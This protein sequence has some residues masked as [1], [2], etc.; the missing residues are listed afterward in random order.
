MKKIILLCVAFLSAIA[1]FAQQDSNR[2]FVFTD[3]D[4]NA[5]ENGATIERDKLEFDDF[6]EFK[7]IL[8]EVYVKQTATDKNYAVSMSVKINSID[9]GTLKVC[10]PMSCLQLVKPGT[11]DL[12]KSTL[13]E[14]ASYNKETGMANILTEWIP[15][16]EDAWGMCEAT[17]T[18]TTLIKKSFLDYT[19][20]G[21]SSEIT[22]RFINRDPAGSNV[23]G[24]PTKGSCFNGEVA[25]R[26]YGDVTGKG[27][28]LATVVI[29]NNED[30]T[31]NIAI[32]GMKLY[33]DL[34]TITFKNIPGKELRGITRFSSDMEF[35]EA[36]VVGSGFNRGETKMTV[37]G[38]FKKDKC[39]V[40]LA[41]KFQG[42]GDNPFQIWIGSPIE[43]D[44]FVYKV[45]AE[46]T[47]GD[48]TVTHEADE[49]RVIDYGDGTMKFVYPRFTIAESNILIGDY[50]VSNVS[51]S[52]PDENGYRNF[53]SN[54]AAKIANP[55]SFAAASG[56]G[57]EQDLPTI[58]S[59]RY[60][61]KSIEMK[62]EFMVSGS[63]TAPRARFVFDSTPKP[64]VY[65]G[66]ASSLYNGTS[67]DFGNVSVDV[68]G[69]DDTCIYEFVV[70][71]VA[72]SSMVIGNF[73]VT[74]VVGTKKSDGSIS[75]SFAGKATVTDV[76]F[77]ASQTFGFEEG[78][79]INVKLNGESKDGK[80]H[81]ELMFKD[82]KENDVV[83]TFDSKLPAVCNYKDI[84]TSFC[85]GEVSNFD[86][87][88]VDISEAADGSYDIAAKQV[89][90]FSVVI[91]DITATGVAGKT[92]SDGS[93]SFSYKGLAKTTNVGSSAWGL[94]ENGDIEVDLDALSKDGK[95]D[96]VL[97]FKIK[98][99][100]VTY[101]FGEELKASEGTTCRYTD[102]VSACYQA[103]MYDKDVAS[104]AI[105]ETGA[106]VY[107][108]VVD[109]VEVTNKNGYS[110][111]VGGITITDVAGTANSDGSISYTFD[112]N[113]IIGTPSV[114]LK[115][116]LNAQSYRRKLYM[117]LTYED[118]ETGSEIIYTF[119]DKLF[120]IQSI[121]KAVFKIGDDIVG[122]K[123]LASGQT[124]TAIEAPAKEGHT[125]AGWNDIPATMP[126][127]DIEIVG[128]YTVNSYHL[129]YILDG[130]T[131]KE[132]DVPFGTKLTPEAAPE[133]KG[134][135]FSGWQELPETMPSH[136]VEVNGV[137]NVN[138][139]EDTDISAHSDILYF[140]KTV[141]VAGSQV[142]LS[143]KMRNR[144]KA[145]AYQCDLYLPDG[146]EVAK[147]AD[148]SY[149][150]ELSTER[151]T[152]ENSNVFKSA[153]QSDGC[154]RILSASTSNIAYNGN[155]G[156]VATIVLQL[157]DSLEEGDLPIILRNVEIA[158]ANSANNVIDFVKS[159]L[160]VSAYTVGDV[161]N[162]GRISITDF[163]A[164]VEYLMGNVP[165]VFI[166][167]AADIS[168]D[169]K[170]SVTDLTSLVPLIMQ[171]TNASPRHASPSMN[172]E[173]AY[174]ELS[175]ADCF[176]GRGMECT[177]DVK[178]TG[179]YDFSAYQFDLDLPE[180]VRVKM[181]NGKPCVTLVKS[182]ASD[183][184]PNVFTSSIMPDGS[185]RVLGAT[186]DGAL[187]NKAD[188]CIARITLVADRDTAYGLHNATIGNIVLAANGHDIEPEPTAF[189]ISVGDATGI[190]GIDAGEECGDIYDVAGKMVKHNGTTKGLKRGIYIM[191][192]KKVLK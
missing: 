115:V 113:A 176:M 124:V 67:T 109:K 77:A 169:G 177:V 106:G 51:V 171:G 90:V 147:N 102:K 78:D 137:F 112:G 100:P 156:E 88:F 129:T 71:Q 168:G 132:A 139:D 135:I 185:L 15:K 22:I 111:P 39:Y 182:D 138:P 148:G 9:N 136:D 80:L 125:F 25:Y 83:Y 188:G 57:L 158:D 26:F 166:E 60:N 41:G 107:K 28:G 47:Y 29:T 56:L 157:S 146:V 3:K 33:V 16:S 103:D 186:T 144:L 35:V 13:S 10:F 154:I 153:L 52:E 54:N 190:D 58:I 50:S 128:S 179:N 114:P 181:Q 1:T 117:T 21:K 97:K 173:S 61:E 17:F 187:V 92:N 44:A 110:L 20:V 68:Y 93:I 120:Y 62:G 86:E 72:V 141:G 36:E 31:Y 192:G 101:M 149:K 2:V 59:G 161:N 70:K 119:G 19:T 143:L 131:Y 116:T 178:V 96:M 145:V 123:T 95:L 162:D 48:D 189:S 40:E 85:G 164:I 38:A 150:I 99:D 74:D 6:E 133:K 43:P 163:T 105:L 142:V 175:A 55:S 160:T 170:I 152:A 121:H 184:L 7:Q 159:T 140:D 91:G 49:V 98:D 42:W 104:V 73:T 14:T 127:H 84:A 126:D 82:G 12:G 155:D 45:K 167:K 34:G 4:G 151:T 64:V 69:F 46:I 79:S 94:K 65:I 76:G 87:A 53:T 5:F 165:A 30:G 174:A 37:K 75:Y 89:R 191:N 63:G 27:D 24:A 134:Y 11:S 8:S 32:S 183:H 108:F 23:S 180:G 130:E 18:L 118:P 66:N 172:S 81:I 122:T